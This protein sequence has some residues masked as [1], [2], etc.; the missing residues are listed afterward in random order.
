MLCTFPLDLS[1]CC[2]YVDQMASV[3][4]FGYLMDL[5]QQY[6]G[7][8]PI[9]PSPYYES[10]AIG[11]A[12]P[13]EAPSP[14]YRRYDL[15]ASPPWEQPERKAMELV[16][17]RLTAAQLTEVHSSMTKGV[18]HLRITRVG[19]A[20]GLLARC[21]SEVEPEFKPTDTVSYVVNVRPFVAS[22]CSPTY[23]VTA[24]RNGFVPGQRS[25]QCRHLALHWTAS[26]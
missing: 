10:K 8:G 1:G 21:L 9:G 24:P 23:P 14:T 13:P 7:L 25:G 22:P 6:Q 5:S 11:F 18:K 16:A 20:M 17:F 26:P 12:E 19:V 2:R 3:D 15:S 4:A